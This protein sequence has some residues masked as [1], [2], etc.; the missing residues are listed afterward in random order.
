M[1]SDDF[2]P[3]DCRRERRAETATGKGSSTWI[4]VRSRTRRYKRPAGLS[5]SGRA[6]EQQSKRKAQRFHESLL[7][8]VHS[9]QIAIEP[10]D[11]P[12]DGVDLVLALHEAVT[13]VGVI[14]DIDGLAGVF[15][16]RDHLL[17]FFLRHADVVVALHTSS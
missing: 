16:D 7:I 6:K 3:G 1:E 11:H 12:P 10:V 14:V 15:Q 9:F 13:L 17:R 5:K 8:I 2:A 4:C